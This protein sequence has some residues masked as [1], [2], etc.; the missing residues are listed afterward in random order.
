LASRVVSTWLASVQTCAGSSTPK[1]LAQTY[2]TGSAQAG[3]EVRVMTQ[4]PS[5]DAMNVASVDTIRDRRLP[6]CPTRR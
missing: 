6:R 1:T 4:N 2:S 5:A 3:S